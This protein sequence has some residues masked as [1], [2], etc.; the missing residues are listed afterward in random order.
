MGETAYRQDQKDWRAAENFR[1]EEDDGRKIAI[2]DLTAAEG[3]KS[4]NLFPR[5]C[6]LHGRIAVCIFV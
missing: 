4:R 1:A 5:C 6:G 2:R 3:L